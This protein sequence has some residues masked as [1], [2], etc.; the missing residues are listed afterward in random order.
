M[1]AVS[2]CFFC[3]IA[4]TRRYLRFFCTHFPPCSPADTCEGKVS[5]PSL[6]LRFFSSFTTPCAFSLPTSIMNVLCHSLSL[7]RCWSSHL[8]ISPPSF[9]LRGCSL[10][11]ARGS[12]FR[13]AL[14]ANSHTGARGR[15][16]SSEPLGFG[17]P[18]CT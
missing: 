3:C 17:R 18:A 1:R 10:E 5:Q 12:N 13:A 6:G 16:C 15:Q 4:L 7:T 11:Q 9:S 2:A 8:L 14:D